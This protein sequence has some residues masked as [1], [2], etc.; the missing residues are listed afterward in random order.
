M[1]MLNEWKG[2]N[3]WINAPNIKGNKTKK[4]KKS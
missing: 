4:K 2:V 1:I 3:V